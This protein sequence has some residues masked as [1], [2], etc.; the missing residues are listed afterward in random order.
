M[1]T[2]KQQGASLIV[3]LVF[4]A[5]LTIA[6]ITAARLATVEERMAGNSQSRSELYQ[7]TQSEIR[8]Q[9]ANFNKDVGKR[10]SLLSAAN[11]GLEPL[12]GK[13]PNRRTAVDLSKLL[14]KDIGNAKI[15]TNTVRFITKGNCEG[16]SIGKFEC[17]A[18][19]L[20]TKTTHE[21]GAYSDQTQGIYFL[22]IK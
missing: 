16:A 21:N 15:S 8:A 22:N 1:M 10:A 7:A 6:G 4:L 13:L 2:S 11:A 14:D 9:I 12:V 17:S 18:Y 20:N 5:V 3:A 19:E